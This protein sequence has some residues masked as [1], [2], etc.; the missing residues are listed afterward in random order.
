M[1]PLRA[2]RGGGGSLGVVGYLA[3]VA[4][5]IA[6]VL[7]GATWLSLNACR[8]KYAGVFVRLQGNEKDFDQ[9]LLARQNL[10]L[11]NLTARLQTAENALSRLRQLEAR[12]QEAAAKIN[13]ALA[14]KAG[15]TRAV[16]AAKAAVAPQAADEEKAVEESSDEDDEAKKQ[17]QEYSVQLK[18]IEYSD[19]PMATN[20][21]LKRFLRFRP[22]HKCG[23]RAPPL[24]DDTVVECNPGGPSPCC[25]S[26]G[27]CGATKE[28]C[29]CGTCILYRKEGGGGDI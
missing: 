16:P 14:T 2:S 18:L 8:S 1:A 9:S 7:L 15:G 4:A 17:Q 27:W 12:H 19:N 25:S 11:R 26:L 23:S 29:K 3:L 21:S 13:E 6:T 10:I 28:H 22:D 5:A 20:M 24:P